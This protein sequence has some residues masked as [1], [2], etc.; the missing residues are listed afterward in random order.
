MRIAAY[1]GGSQVPSARA[2]VRQYIEP[3]RALDIRVTEYP[4]PWGNV[5]PRRRSL[6]PIWVGSTAA[7]RLLS[8]TRSWTAD[9]TWVSRQL[10]PA[11]APVHLLARRPL[12]LDVDDAVWLN[13]GGH[14]A[15][16]LARSS[17]VVVCGNEYLAD[18][19]RQWNSA[20]HV[21]P[22]AIDTHL[23][24]PARR[25]TSSSDAI[26]LGWSGTSVNFPLLYGIEKALA[27]VMQER[28]NV[29]LRVMADRPPR[30]THLPGARVDFVRWE[31]GLEPEVIQQMSIGLMPLVEDAWC[32]G[33]CSYKMLCYM[34]CGVPVV[35]SP[36][37]MNREV[38]AYGAMGFGATHTNDWVDAF[39]ELIDNAA[40]RK[41]M[42]AEGRSVVERHFSLDHLVPA[43]AEILR[44]VAHASGKAAVAEAA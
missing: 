13:T 1:T 26:V 41:Q 5:L 27:C 38:L 23:L 31:P 34:A 17:T 12:V 4:L 36:V 24:H 40:L 15:K 35:V 32:A 43:Y 39:L 8:L 37:G 29:R 22:T 21:I 10:L 18:Y 3:L 33:K 14:R 16:D 44:T 42:G 6:R 19:Y 25:T 11:F 7:A 28:R 2:R 20:V 30:F 9:V